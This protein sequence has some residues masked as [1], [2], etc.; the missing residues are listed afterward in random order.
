MDNGVGGV[1]DQGAVRQ[2]HDRDDHVPDKGEYL[3]PVARVGTKKLLIIYALL[4]E[5]RARLA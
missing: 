3:L 2:L 5:V 4:D 1:L